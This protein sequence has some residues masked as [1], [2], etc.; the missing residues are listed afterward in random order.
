VKKN[1]FICES[2]A[3]GKTAGTFFRIGYCESSPFD[4][5]AV[6]LIVKSPA[7]CSFSKNDE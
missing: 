7:D 4:S 2:Q 1:G 6:I 3:Q 5:N